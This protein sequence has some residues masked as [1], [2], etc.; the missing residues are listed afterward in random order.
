MLFFIISE[1]QILRSWYKKT[2]T[3]ARSKKCSLKSG[4]ALNN[5]NGSGQ[6]FGFSSFKDHKLCRS[7][8]GMKREG[9]IVGEDGDSGSSLCKDR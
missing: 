9:E 8:E 1:L 5:I 6:F 3:S 4:E 2:T 7:A